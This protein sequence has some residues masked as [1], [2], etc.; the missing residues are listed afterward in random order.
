MLSHVDDP[1]RLLIVSK[2]GRSEFSQDRA[3]AFSFSYLSTTGAK[4][5]KI[6]CVIVLRF[7]FA[8]CLIASLHPSGRRNMNLSLSLAAIFQSMM[9]LWH[10]KDATVASWMQLIFYATVAETGL[11]NDHINKPGERP[12]HRTYA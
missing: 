8:D 3:S 12:L 5:A 6:S 10:N 2:K 1:S 11:K 4:M 7:S 9:P